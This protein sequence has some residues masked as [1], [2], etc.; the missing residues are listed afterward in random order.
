MRPSF[1]LWIEFPSVLEHAVKDNEQIVHFVKSL[2]VVIEENARP[3]I[4]PMLLPR[5]FN[6]QTVIAPKYCFGSLN[7]PRDIVSVATVPITAPLS[8]VI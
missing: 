5:K 2:T 7:P 1:R 8:Y 4:P 3:K 6:E